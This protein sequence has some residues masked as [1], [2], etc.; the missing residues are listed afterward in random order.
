MRFARFAAFALPSLLAL[1]VHAQGTPFPTTLEEAGKAF[2]P[3][4]K[5]PPP[6]TTPPPTT[7]PPPAPTST[8]ALNEPRTIDGWTLVEVRSGRRAPD[9]TP[10]GDACGYERDIVV[11]RVLEGRNHMT[12]AVLVV[13]CAKGVDGLPTPGKPSLKLPAAYAGPA[14]P[15]MTAAAAD[16]EVGVTGALDQNDVVAVV[17]AHRAEVDA[18]HAAGKGGTLVTRIVVNAAGVAAEAAGMSGPLKGSAVDKCVAKAVKTWGFTQPSDGRPAVVSLGLTYSDKAGALAAAGAPSS[19]TCGPGEKPKKAEE[20]KSGETACVPPP[21]VKK[22]RACAHGEVPKAAEDLREGE[23]AC[24]PEASER[25]VPFL[26]GELTHLGDIRLVNVRT[27]FGVGIGLNVIDSVYFAVL[28][29]DL[30]LRFGDFGLGIG[31]PLQF[32]IA[33]LGK[34]DFVN[35]NPVDD[36]FGNAGRFR[37]QD[38]DQ[39]ED[40]LKPLRYLT[41]GKKEDHLY[42]DLNR[43]HA[44]TIGHGQLVRRYAPNIDI[45]EDNLF[46]QVDGYGDYGGVE[47]MAGPFPLP[48]L[49]GGLVFVKPMGIVQGF[50]DSDPDAGSYLDTLADSWSIG[51][52]Y[53]TDLNTPTGLEGRFNPADQRFQLAVDASNQLVWRNKANPIGDVVQGIGFDTEVK[54]L[55]VDNVD[56]K[57][58]GD[59][60]HLFFPAD[61][62]SAEAFQ[63]FDG[64]G[65]TVG[66][67]LRASLGTKP[68]RH[69]DDEDEETKAGHKPR[70]KKAA[71]AFR[72]RLEGRT[73]APTYLPSYWNTMY[74][75]DRFQFGFSDNRS[76]LPTKIGY[77]ASQQESALRVGYFVE[78]SYE[79]VD[80]V[81]I[82]AAFE[83]A[84]PLGDVDDPVRAKNFALHVE[85][86]GLGWLQLFASYHYRNFDTADFPR[87]FSFAT[88]NE[89]LFAGAR[90][91]VLPIMFVNI[92]AQ[93]S[94]RLGFA[95]DD[96]PGQLDNK[97][98]RFS[99]VGLENVWAGGFDV[100]LGWQ[101]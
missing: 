45:D 100:E 47:V 18:C 49:V 58:Y 87:M 59:Y 39:V 50:Q 77:L 11:E 30:N 34:I 43:V 54:V 23:L 66:G 42:I 71:H 94:F 67:L 25:G 24:K 79:W 1:S 44:T 76:L 17:L 55:K 46:A 52:S 38:W 85:S 69:I 60:S 56:I 89:L 26:K 91:Q 40:F 101:F 73:F 36:I 98:Q 15:S 63:A 97:G 68:V 35:G 81:G 92:Q 29:P 31:A 14:K 62:S 75:I 93:R 84:Y 78:A 64:G 53:V 28:R 22:A 9:G 88:D 5:T 8:P 19:R 7:T 4:N 3:T 33:N 99:S 6:P 65:A 41:Y 32:E 90:L 12:P 20:L 51:A 80:A 27:S 21:K 37:T 70:E 74:E 48:R 72:V 82:T 10:T 57:V 61:S 83:D 2:D 86:Q 96:T 16:I 13:P 95:E